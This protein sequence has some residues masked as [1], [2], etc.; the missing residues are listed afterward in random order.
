[1]EAYA[2]PPGKKTRISPIAVNLQKISQQI[3]SSHLRLIL[4]F[5][6]PL[7][8]LVGKG[9][10]NGAIL[11]VPYGINDKVEERELIR[12]GLSFLCG[13]LLPPFTPLALSLR[14]HVEE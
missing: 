14:T 1:M 4:G 12:K 3:F 13:E 11:G 8:N 2:T 7:Q 6:F 5:I 9:M 10:Y